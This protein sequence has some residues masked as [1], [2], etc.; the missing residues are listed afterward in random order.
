MVE[1]GRPLKAVGGSASS[2]HT[3]GHARGTTG[4]HTN[5][6][7]QDVLFLKV[8]EELVEV[9]TPEV[10]DGSQSSEQ[11]LAR[12]LLEVALADVLEEKKD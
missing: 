7:K 6:G 9:W 5:L 2:L 12:Q 10:G 4:E 11:T 1:E 3:I 8:V